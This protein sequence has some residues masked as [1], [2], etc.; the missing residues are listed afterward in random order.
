MNTFLLTG[1][2]ERMETGATKTGWQ[3]KTYTIRVSRED[4][5]KLMKFSKQPVEDTLQL[6]DP[7]FAQGKLKIS[8]QKSQK[9]FEFER[10]DLNLNRIERMEF[11]FFPRSES[12]AGTYSGQ[13]VA[14]FEDDVP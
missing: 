6:G 4:T 9:G 7:V 1:S 5:V 14:S 3:T 11:D 10:I 12:D 13:Q 8:K 2:L